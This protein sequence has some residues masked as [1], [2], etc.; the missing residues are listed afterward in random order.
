MLKN[1]NHSKNPYYIISPR[2][3]RTSAGVRVL[4][5]LADL[6][7][8][9][10]GSAFVYLRPYF[11]HELASSPMD[12]APFLNQKIVNYHFMNG[13][14]P[15]VIY[16]ETTRVSKFNPPMRVRYL[17]NYDDL[18]FENEPLEM[19]D[20]LLSY[21][22]AIAARIKVDKPSS[23]LFLPVSDAVFFCPPNG[24]EFRSG[25]V[26]YA[27]KFKYHFGGKTQP[28]TA[29]M[30]EI[31]RD[32][33]DSQTQEQI[34]VLFQGAEFFY[35]YEDSAL[36]LEAILCGCPVVFLPNEHFISPLGA[37]EMAGLGYAWGISPEGLK[38][39]KETVVAARERYLSILDE[40]QNKIETFID[41]TQRIVAGR[42]Y[43]TPFASGMFM[44]PGV[45]RLLADLV[46]F[47]RNMV[48]DRGIKDTFKIVFKRI[49]S[50]R[51]R[52]A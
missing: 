45:F 19:D 32:R 4:F 3:V 39:A 34:R 26:F 12:V 23:T 37:R 29:G 46:Y 44:K 20:Y 49:L 16:P 2:Y 22:D 52:I 42:S 40:C 11:N 15:I 14:T 25:G 41:E 43:E 21:S 51:F 31:T 7:N 50:G 8:R 18:L 27:G 13:L 47:M 35:C 9:A 36:A 48:S 1:S 33:P 6:I 10:G 5:R 38:H 24:A 30:P 17:L 28:A